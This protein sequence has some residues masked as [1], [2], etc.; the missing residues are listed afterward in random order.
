MPN[1]VGEAETD[2]LVSA[3]IAGDERA[4]AVLTERHR[5]ELHVHCYRMLASFDEAEDAVQET[6]LRAW[7][8]RDGF[9]GGAL[10]RAWLYRIA[11]NVCL[12]ELRRGSRKP[13]SPQSFAEVPW[14]QPYPDGLLDAAAPDADRPEAVAV[15]RETI[16]LAFLAALQTLPPR[17]RA[18]LIARDVLGWPAAQTA[19]ALGTSV[20]AANSALQRARATM[21][22]HL[23]ARRSE[24]TSG[25]ASAEERQVLERFIDAHERC[26]M[27][28]ALAI[29][30]EDIRV[31]MPPLPACHDGRDEI[32]ALLERAFGEDREGDWR[33]LPAWANRMPAAASY[34]RRPGDSVFRAFK[35]D[36]L[37]VENGRI[38]EITTFGTA[39]FPAFGLPATP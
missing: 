21:Q 22:R 36:V 35:L 1:A 10:F 29:A 30:A 19:S 33:L 27:A 16:E 18:A 31:T 34:L 26:D 12:D 7:R 13:A 4:F 38:V 23:P 20:A 39:L 25:E 5:R 17:Q 3:A 9:G 28:A 37:R 24:W 14:M 2:P 8:G 32:A 6:F 15:Q 11:T